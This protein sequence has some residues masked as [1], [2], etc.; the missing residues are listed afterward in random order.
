MVGE[1][2]SSLGDRPKGSRGRR[3]ERKEGAGYHK[4]IRNAYS[5][6]E[7]HTKVNI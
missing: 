3:K 6:G 5:D 4:K 7:V 1:G 2:N